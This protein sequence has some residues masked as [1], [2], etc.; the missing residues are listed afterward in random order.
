MTTIL[1][2][3]SKDRT[4]GTNTNFTWHT[5]SLHP[6]SITLKEVIIPNL[7]NN[8]RSGENST[9]KY[10]TGG[11]DYTIGITDGQYPTGDLLNVL[12]AGFAVN[13]H[14][15]T[16]T[17]DPYSRKIT[18]KN[19]MAEPLTIYNNDNQDTPSTLPSQL[20]YDTDIPI[21]ASSSVEFNNPVNIISYMTLN[22]L[23]NKLSNGYNVIAAN[24][25]RYPIICTLPI[26]DAP[27]NS[28]L[29]YEPQEQHQVHQTHSFN[30][31]EIDIRITDEE[32]NIVKLPSNVDVIIVMEL[33]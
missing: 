5:T 16:L 27:F 25:Q 6:T 10:R 2:I 12:T 11:Q 33:E 20:G 18:F 9:F 21:G 7:F 32:F 8:I 24:E 29:H 14:D 30:V 17:Q 31:Q 13:L 4:S 22:V 28:V 26:S 19:N 1:K 23:S 15:V 3:N